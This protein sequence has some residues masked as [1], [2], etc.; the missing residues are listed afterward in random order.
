MASRAFDAPATATGMECLSLRGRGAALFTMR[1]VS[2]SARIR[3]SRCASRCRTALGAHEPV[4]A[5]STVLGF[6]II[7][8]WVLVGP[9]VPHADVVRFGLHLPMVRRHA[10]AHGGTL[11]RSLVSARGPD[12]RAALRTRHGVHGGAGDSTEQLPLIARAAAA[13]H[14]LLLFHAGRCRSARRCAPTPCWSR[15]YA[16]RR[17]CWAR[18]QPTSRPISCSCWSAPISSA[19]AGC[20][21]LEHANRVAFLD[22]RRLDGS[23]HARRA[24]RAAEPRG[25]RRA[26]ARSCGS[27]PRATA[28]GVGRARRHRSLQGVQRSLRASGWRPCLRD[29]AA[30]MRRVARRRPLDLVAR[31]GGEEFIAVLFGADRCACRACGAQRARSRAELQFRIRHPPRGRTSP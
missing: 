12:R 20:Y 30:A 4:V 28:A 9:R 6:A 3:I 29:V 13:R 22:R 11:L 5:L 19:R 17:R 21:A 18:S 1:H 23:R 27:R 31:Y 10:G 24:H 16:S 15:G 14:V 25:A 2:P 26:G 7:D 8:H